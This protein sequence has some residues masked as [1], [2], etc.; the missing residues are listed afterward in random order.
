M[1]SFFV[2]VNGKQKSPVM[3]LRQEI[4][5]TWLFSKQLKHMEAEIREIKDYDFL[6]S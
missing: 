6:H 3:K 4:D 1:W 2:G 5:L